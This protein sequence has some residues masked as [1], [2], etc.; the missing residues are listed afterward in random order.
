MRTS[1]IGFFCLLASSLH[2]EIRLQ[3]A[4]GVEV[5]LAKPAQRIVSLAPHITEVVY[6]AGAGDQLIGAVSYSDYPQAALNVPR[7]GSYDKVSYE[8]LV[9]LKPDLVLA[10]SSGNGSE[11]VNRLRE[12]GLTVFAGEPRTLESV[13]ESVRQVGYLSG[14]EEQAARA[15][16]E[17]IAK[18][19]YLRETYSD[20]DTLSVY[21][22]IWNEPLL[23]LNGEHLISDVVRLCGGRNIFADD[24]P[25]VLRINVE[26]VVRADP[27][28]I[29]A[30]GMDEARPEWLD[31][32]RPWTSIQAVKEDQLYF[33]PPD[34]LQRHT[35]RIMQGAEQM[36]DYLAR[37]RTHYKRL[38]HQ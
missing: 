29:I 7:V 8:T 25:M 17:F 9:D 20:Q 26:S 28:V 14:N 11:T 35:P 12:L 38:Q 10:W 4:T 2:A 33:I 30:S 5:V 6:A 24:Q 36:C 15:A 34:I 22:Q 37:A 31:D 32:W 19:T 16:D 23:S 18:L 27:Q 3:D 21:Y 1:L 13:A